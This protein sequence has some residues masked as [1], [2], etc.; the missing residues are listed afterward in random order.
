MSTDIIQN[1]FGGVSCMTV[2]YYMEI[3]D[4]K[5]AFVC[6]TRPLTAPSLQS[7]QSFP[8]DTGKRQNAQLKGD[9]RSVGTARLGSA[10][11]DPGRRPSMGPFGL[12]SVSVRLQLA[13]S[14]V[15]RQKTEIGTSPLQPAALGMQV[16]V[17]SAS[18]IDG[19]PWPLRI[20]CSWS[21][22]RQF[23]GRPSHRAWFDRS[24]CS[25]W[26]PR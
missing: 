4:D 18:S 3:D 15:D 10:R 16:K 12:R 20:R 24:I 7:W 17:S 13:A 9:V 8:C 26:L 1:H 5:C 14:D 19:S 22:G 21:R 6:L 23:G 2:R 11:W 25:R